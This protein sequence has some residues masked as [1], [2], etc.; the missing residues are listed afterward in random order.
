MAEGVSKALRDSVIY[1]GGQLL[2]RSVGFLMLPI[3][4]RFLTPADYGVLS[5][6]VVAVQSVAAFTGLQL[7][8]ALF[9]YYY[10][11]NDA[12]TR[13]VM[14]STTLILTAGT[15]IATTI[16]VVIFSGSLASVFLGDGGLSKLVALFAVTMI[17]DVLVYIPMQYLRILNR[18]KTYVVISLIKLFCQVSMNV[19]FLV[20][21]GFGVSGVIYANIIAGFGVGGALVV[22]TLSKTGARVSLKLVGQLSSYSWP[23]IFGGIL[24][25]YAYQVGAISLSH[26]SGLAEVGI[27]ALAMK[28]NSMIPLLVT[29]P[30][31]QAWAPQR[32]RIRKQKNAIDVYQKA[33]LVLMFGVVVVATAVALLSE[34]I[35][36][37]MASPEFW[38]AAK[39]V[40]IICL[41]S[42]VTGL[43]EYCKFGVLV[44]DRTYDVT[45]SMI[46]M[47][48]GV[49]L[50]LVISNEQMTALSVIFGL[51][52]GGVLSV[53]WV[54]YKGKRNLDMKL[55]WRRFWLLLLMA[56]GIFSLS[57][58][59]P[60]NAWI[61]IPAK[62]LL[63]VGLVVGAYASPV[64]GREGREVVLSYVKDIR[65]R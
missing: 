11:T 54:V 4:T 38:P 64:F 8:H 41:F 45:K 57:A 42:I 1:G 61:A 36:Y 15:K 62:I 48:G 6:L 43:Y 44:T 55:P 26:M 22:W 18:P 50:V 34:N 60:D 58:V 27:F 28:F 37:F 12:T 29:E 10:E 17:S 35:I 52:F 7:V 20:F 40:P 47:A 19:W 53:V 24:T 25:L 14:I 49:S 46:L 63:L 23:L 39:L 59:L 3:Y 56:V 65:R 30:F 33:F 16:L 9:R 5:L 21:M 51:L 31:M 2:Q 32:F 13:K